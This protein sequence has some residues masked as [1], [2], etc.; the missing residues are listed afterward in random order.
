MKKVFPLKL[1]GKVDQRVVEGVKSD[2]RR[3]VKRERGKALPEG[4][5]RWDFACKVGADAATAV[6]TPLG[7]IG[8][9]IDA[10]VNTGGTAVYIEI[11][12][13]PARRPPPPAR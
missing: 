9:A 5:D 8:A 3:Y 13:Q 7:A 1:P 11:L 6:K 4:F 10:I 2:V 12:A